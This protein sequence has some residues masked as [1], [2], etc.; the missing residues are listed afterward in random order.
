MAGPRYTSGDR[1][2]VDVEGIKIIQGFPG[3]ALKKDAWE[4]AQIRAAVALG[5]G[6]ASEA[7]YRVVD[8]QLAAA[9]V[10]YQF[11]T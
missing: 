9:P 10:P 7:E 5:L 11:L 8:R 2:A 4:Y 1:V 6:A 3:N